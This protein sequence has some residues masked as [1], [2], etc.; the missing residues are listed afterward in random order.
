[1]SQKKFTVFL[2]GEY[3][4]LIV[5]IGYY[6]ISNAELYISLLLL[7]RCGVVPI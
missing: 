6:F 3:V 5:I 7:S 1:M 2:A 4:I